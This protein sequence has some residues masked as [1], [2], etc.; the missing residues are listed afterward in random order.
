MSSLSRPESLLICPRCKTM[1][2]SNVAVCSTCGLQTTPGRPESVSQPI[3]SRPVQ[4]PR[5][6]S[7]RRRQLETKNRT[8]ITLV[9]FFSSFFILFLVIFA[10]LRATGTSLSTLIS[11]LTTKPAITH[12]ISYSTPKVAPLFADNFIADSG[13]NLQSVRGNYAVIINNNTLTMEVDKNKLLWELMPG[14]ASYGDF[15]LTV[16]AVLSRGDQNNGYGVYIRGASNPGSDLASYYRFE[17]YG[18]GSY[19]IFKGTVGQGGKSIETKI[20]NYTLD[21]AIQ[22]QGK[23]NR[24]I[25]IAK[26][27]SMS[28]IVNDHLLK[29][30]SDDSYARG[31]VALFASNLP[32]ANP[33]MQVQFSKFAL[34]PVQV[35]PPA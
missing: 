31:S 33:G 6:R 29:T 18:D 7:A 9:Y 34:Y 1:L 32:E 28:F 12:T 10:G 16:D 8:G 25:I 20:V 35:A 4:A 21:P 22:K 27:P 23:T 26:G 11:L 19:A 24:I 14:Q 30:F 2:P 5:S 15:M 17:L 3:K 13:W